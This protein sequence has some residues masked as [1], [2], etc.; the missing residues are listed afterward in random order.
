MPKPR[1]PQWA[2]PGKARDGGPRPGRWRTK[3]DGA[4]YYAPATIGRWDRPL[5]GA[6]EKAIP[7]AAWDW[8]HALEKAQSLRSTGG[9]DPAVKLVCDEYLR[10]AMGEVRDGRMTV[11]QWK[12]QR[13][14]LK[15]FG[16][17]EGVGST[18]AAALTVDRVEAFF[19]HLAASG[20]SKHYV[21][22]VGRSV[23]TVFRWAARPVPGRE[24]T[25]LI[26]A[27]PLD[28]FPFPRAP[29][30]VREHVEG[31]VVRRWLRWCWAR[32]RR[33]TGRARRFDRLFL[34][35]VWFQRL[36]G[37]R[38]G[39]ACALRWSDWDRASGK[40]TLA[41]H[42]TA[43]LDKARVVY[44]TTPVVRLLG[45]VEGLEGRHETYVFC[46]MRG[47]GAGRRGHGSADA[48]EPW[49]SGSAASAKVRGLRAG[50]IAARVAGVEAVGTRR[51]VAYVNRHSYA[52]EAINAGMSVE[53]TAELLGNTPQVVAATYAH[54][55]EG[56]ARGRAE[57]LARR[58]KGKTG[59]G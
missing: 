33:Q 32:A 18:A 39:E 23:R 30:S 1:R 37:C 46:H 56:G 45:A 34:L 2:S 49:P 47:R 7:R 28:G 36:T 55:I 31:A 54:L 48:G 57:A 12:G 40:I 51:L 38:P 59:G 5:V 9:S 44:A 8:L 25:R 22:G 17:W 52:S 43:H 10:W 27:N 15:L 24:P 42:K 11:G 4:F 16:G 21:A 20:F 6:G 58:G 14:R 35:M 41:E 19:S 53:H 3:I 13:S 26:A 29:A 50:A